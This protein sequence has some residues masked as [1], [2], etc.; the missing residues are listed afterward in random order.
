[1][2]ALV[3]FEGMAKHLVDRDERRVAAFLDVLAD[4]HLDD[5]ADAWR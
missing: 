4:A 2:D 1:V 5:R 3:Y